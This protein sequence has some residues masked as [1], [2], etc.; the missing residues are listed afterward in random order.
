MDERSQGQALCSCFAPMSPQPLA[1]GPPS[2]QCR[3]AGTWLGGQR[4][5]RGAS[6][7]CQQRVEGRV[8]GKHGRPLKTV[9][10]C[11]A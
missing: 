10:E 4:D 9:A 8:M 3:R 7:T 1:R 11:S 2:T 5:G 6:A